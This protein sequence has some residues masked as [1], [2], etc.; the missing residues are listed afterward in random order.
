MTTLS[1]HKDVGRLLLE[2][3]LIT[4]EQL[5]RA[6][7]T[8]ASQ[9]KSIGRI[10]VDMGVITEEAKIAFIHKKLNHEIVDIRDMEIDPSTVGRIPLSFAEKHRCVPILVEEDK[11]VMAMEDPADIAV[12]DAIKAQTGMEPLPVL[13]PLHD[14]E[15]ALQQIPRL[16]QREA[17]ALIAQRMA[18]LWARVLHPL[19]F[20][21]IM[22]APLA[23]FF[24]LVKYS[25][26]FSNFVWQLGQPFD[27]M[28]YLVLSWALWAILLW[29]ADSLV[30][31]R[32]SR[33]G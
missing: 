23:M 15:Q 8:Q 9:E 32:R 28:L 22:I 25:D 13:A 29:E 11:L 16:S 18:P 20:M 21:L 6:R 12:L 1:E 4:R 3:G 17:D 31:S 10:L 19:L 24:V 26:A 2:A 7:T 30:F 33:S 27:V 14:I 5:D